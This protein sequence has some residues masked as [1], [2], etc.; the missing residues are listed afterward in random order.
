MKQAYFQDGCPT[1][2]TG[3]T[4]WHPNASC[5]AI[6]PESEESMITV[7]QLEELKANWDE[8]QKAQ[9][10]ELGSLDARIA[11]LQGDRKAIIKCRDNLQA[12]IKGLE[13]SIAAAK[14][15]PAESKPTNEHHCA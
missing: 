9:H 4:V 1:E 15:E 11:A 2:E 13:M 3:I 6:Q 14:G 12:G 7:A 5:C 10:R 8:Q